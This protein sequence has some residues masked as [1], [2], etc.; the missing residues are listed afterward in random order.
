LNGEIDIL[1]GVNYQTTAK[2]ALHTTQGCS[3]FNLPQGVA[4]GGWDTAIG[5]PDSKTGIPDMTMR[6][7]KNCFCYDKHQWVNQGCV[8]VDDKNEHMGIPLN[9]KGGGIFVLE[10]DPVNRHIRSWAF[11]QS[12]APQNL[13]DAIRTAKNTSK[14]QVE[15]DPRLWPLPYAYFAIGEGTDCPASHFQNMHI[16]INLAICGSV[17]GGRYFMDC[18]NQFKQYKTCEEWVKSKPKEL[19][20]AY[21]KIKGVYVYQREW[22]RN[23]SE[24]GTA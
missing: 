4:T 15:P 10:W 14:E 18:P 22:A 8:A 5:V 16:V 1:E 13:Q 7:A 20:E 24:S 9:Q 6:Y 19:N 12:E 23:W 21:W 17:A 11:L 2:T 3:H